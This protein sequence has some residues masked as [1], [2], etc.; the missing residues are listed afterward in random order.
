MSDKLMQVN[1][2]QITSRR[3]NS[4]G[5]S[6]LALS[7]ATIFSL[8]YDWKFSELWGLSEKVGI[9]QEE[10]Q[11]VG[12]VVL[13]FLMVVHV[14]NC[15]SD[16]VVQKFNL[17]P[18]T[19]KKISN[20]KSEIYRSERELLGMAGSNAGQSATSTI[21]MREVRLFEQRDILK[22]YQA[23]WRNYV[24]QLWVLHILPP[25]MAGLIAVGWLIFETCTPWA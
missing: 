3:T 1:A 22:K 25:L 2:D 17:L 24:L 5:R 23:A 18:A 9:N 4:S 15:H 7:V 6:L 16:Y 20:M 10:L 14:I 11:I 19:Y 12:L 8:K 13:S 21:D